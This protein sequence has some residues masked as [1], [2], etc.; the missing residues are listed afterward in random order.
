MAADSA[1]L[2]C[3]QQKLIANCN[4]CAHL[5]GVSPGLRSLVMLSKDRPFAAT[6][7]ASLSA[8]FCTSGSEGG[9]AGSEK[10]AS[11]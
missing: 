3:K 7:W 10:A 2:T 11:S 5:K 8:T 4:H 1:L 6:K 9:F